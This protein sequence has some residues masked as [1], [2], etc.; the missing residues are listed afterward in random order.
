MREFEEMYFL[1]AKTPGQ[2]RFRPVDWRKGAQVF[3]II[4]ASMFTEEQMRTLQSVDLAH[5]DNAHI[6][7]EFRKVRGWGAKEQQ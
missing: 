4:H 7:F 1:Y 6:T 2:S 5:P 3:N